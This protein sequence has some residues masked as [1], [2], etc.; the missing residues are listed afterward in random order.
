ME[1]LFASLGKTISLRGK[2]QMSFEKAKEHL[3]KFNFENRIITFTQVSKTVEQASQLL[4]CSEGEIAK[5]LSFLVNGSPIVIVT[6]GDAKISNSKYKSEFGVKAKMIDY[7]QVETL[8]GHEV[9]G[10]CPF[11]L[12]EGV[13]VYL[14][15]TIKKHNTIYPACGN[16][17]S[18][19]RLSPDDFEKLVKVEKWVDV[20]VE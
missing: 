17:H 19:V 20:C 16:Y 12:N 11:G 7:N 2:K 9:G 14:D 3:K 10:V 1:K 4:G 6:E 13:K 5:T 8:T 15:K 18:A